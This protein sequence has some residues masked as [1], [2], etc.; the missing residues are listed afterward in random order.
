MLL[1]R[2]KISFQPINANSDNFGFRPRGYICT[3]APSLCLAETITS[4][5][6]TKTIA[7]RH[8]ARGRSSRRER[9]STIVVLLLANR[10]PVSPAV[11][12]GKSRKRSKSEGRSPRSIYQ[13]ASGCAAPPRRSLRAHTTT[14]LSSRWRIRYRVPPRARAV[15]PPS[16]PLYDAGT[17]ERVLGGLLYIC[18]GIRKHAYMFAHTR[19]RSRPSNPLIGFIRASSITFSQGYTPLAVAVV[20]PNDAYLPR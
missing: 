4:L 1:R 18:M 5:I 16:F 14:K 11:S 12:R 9:P 10:V 7:D 19:S 13:N 2:V 15:A 3:R 17:H 20:R 8:F 6:E